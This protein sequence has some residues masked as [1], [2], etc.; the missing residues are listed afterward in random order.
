M[1]APVQ[2]QPQ[3]PAQ[4][5]CSERTFKLLAFAG[6]L[7]VLVLIH[8]LDPGFYHQIVHLTRGGNIQETVDF[9][10]SFGP[11][12]VVI[13]FLLDVFINA[14]G[15]LP[16]IFLSTA[17]GV[18]FGLPVG[19]LVSWSAESVGVILS[20]LIMRYFLRSTAETV[21][22]KSNNLQ[23]L[24]EMSSENGLVAMAL[25]R[26]LPY[27][28]SGILTCLGAISRMKFRDYVIATFIGKLPSTALEVVVGHDIVHFRQ[29]MDR[30]AIL[31]T[32]VILVYGTLLYSRYRKH[33]A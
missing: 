13:S 25:A 2:S 10:R 22:A 17:N 26:T 29:H 1:E 32:L 11:W 20:F 18:V 3:Y 15:C 24:D 8:F 21:I 31:V 16:S 28:P 6:L 12:A 23:K 7:G 30:L 5:R 14:A 33:R 4:D 9:L 27:F 19:I